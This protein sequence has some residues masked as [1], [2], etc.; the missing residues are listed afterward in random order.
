VVSSGGL[1]GAGVGL[2]RNSVMVIGTVGLFFSTFAT[3][4]QYV[5]GS[6]GIA[7]GLLVAGVLVSAV[8]YGV[9]RLGRDRR[10]PVRVS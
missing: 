8:A 2:R 5:E 10:S 4:E 1:I 9:W 3:I 6:T 7:L